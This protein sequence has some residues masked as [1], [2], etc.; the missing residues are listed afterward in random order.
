MDEAVFNRDS[1]EEGREGRIRRNDSPAFFGKPV[2]IVS[3]KTL[4]SIFPKEITERIHPSMLA[5]KIN[6]RV[7]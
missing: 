7:T 2:I 5:K 1:V 4:K 6:P 3:A